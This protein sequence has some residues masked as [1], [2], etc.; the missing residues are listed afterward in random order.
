[1]KNVGIL[2]AAD[3]TDVIEF[4]QASGVEVTEF[5]RFEHNT[6]AKW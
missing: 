1:L 6:T 4:L 3:T 2:Q 5:T